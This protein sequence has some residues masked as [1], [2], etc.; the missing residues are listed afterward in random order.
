LR[1]ALFPRSTLYCLSRAELLLDNLVDRV[2]GRGRTE[3]V[4]GRVRSSLEFAELDEGSV[5]IPAFCAELDDG[6]RQVAD[7]MAHQYF[8][9]VDQLSIRPQAT[10]VS[11]G[12]HR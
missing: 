9:N 4:L 10:V 8:R 3:T 7:A 5:D 2:P 1:D 6:I 11:M 12:G